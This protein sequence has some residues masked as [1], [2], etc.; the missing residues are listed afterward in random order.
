MLVCSKVGQH[1]MEHDPATHLLQL[2]QAVLQ[3]LYLNGH[4]VTHT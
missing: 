1:C 4:T 2:L 3:L